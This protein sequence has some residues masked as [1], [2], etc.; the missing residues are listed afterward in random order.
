MDTRKIR[1][2]CAAAFWG[3]TNAAAAQL[4]RSGEIDYLVFDYLAE[5]TMSILAA[6]RARDAASGY[7]VD[8]VDDVMAPLAREIA[9][10]GIRVVAHAGGVNPEACRAALQRA[11]DAAGVALRIALVTGDDLQPQR[12]A[13]APSATALDGGP[14][15]PERTLSMNAYLGAAPIAA[16]LARGADVVV[17]GRVA[18]SALVLGPL[19]H[20][21]GWS[22]ADHDRL[23]Q[24]SLAGHVIECGAQCTG[25]NFT[26]WESVPGYENMGFPIVECDAD[27]TFV[28]TKPPGTGG[29]VT[30]FTVGEQI[31]YEIGDPR[32]YLLPDVVC[33][34]TQ[35]RLEA[36]GADRVR[37]SGARGLPPTSTYPC[38]ATWLDGHRI[39]ATFLIGGIDAAR[40]GARVAQAILARVRRLLGEQG[41]PDLRETHVEVLGAEA[42]YGANARAL[43]TR[44]VVVKIACVHDDKRALRV[45]AREIAQ[46][47]TGMA[48][49]LTGII[50]GRPKE[51]PRVRLHSCLV[52]KALVTPWVDID[53][54]VRPVEVAAAGGFDPALLEAQPPGESATGDTP[55]P[56]V[57][58]AVARSGD[59]GD[60]AN[61][62]VIARDRRYLP[63]LRGALT[64]RA[65]AS[66]LAHVLDPVQGRV[67]RWE[68]PGLGGFN[69]LLEHALGGGGIASL[70]ID[71]QGKAYAQQ[72]LDFPVPVPAAL[73]RS[74]A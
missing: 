63:W 42:T 13:V 10:R 39:T 49:G 59:K 29:L 26:D 46:A 68:L 19:I 9:A 47:A 34:F 31:L 18:D 65:V 23:A 21:F 40:K 44:E 53:G 14:P 66:Y 58:L 60:H 64:E 25:G 62:G 52:P 1:V 43:A 30:P 4:V 71:P 32:A 70:R 61:V 51:S 57:K 67:T 22:L 38:S 55:V 3:D 37:V 17:T 6:A 35:V 72:L 56:L 69:F 54:D 33:D 24:G 15:L 7:A 28:V 45:F 41:I 11:F 50:G 73:A 8:F 16:A 20:A 36:I 12:A 5:I 48:P 74:L 27:G 2:G